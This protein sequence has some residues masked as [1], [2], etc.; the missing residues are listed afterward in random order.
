MKSR[1]ILAMALA[2][3]LGVGPLGSALAMG[4]GYGGGGAG[5]GSSNGGSNGVVKGE[6]SVKKCKKGEVRRHKKCVKESYG[7]LYQ[8]GNAVT[9]ADRYE[10]ALAILAA[11][12]SKTIRV[13]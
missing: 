12:K 5:G 13:A 8:R 4:G 11:S 6:Q 2:L 1:T 7:E 9:Q 3:T 10:W